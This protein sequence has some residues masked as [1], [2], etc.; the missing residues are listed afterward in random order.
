MGLTSVAVTGA[1]PVASSSGLFPR[2]R[3][4][5]NSARASDQPG[6]APPRPGG[7]RHDFCRFYPVAV[8]WAESRLFAGAPAVRSDLLRAQLDTRLLTRRLCESQTI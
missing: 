4:G 1:R 2:P 6:R 5:C 7:N 8:A 3:S